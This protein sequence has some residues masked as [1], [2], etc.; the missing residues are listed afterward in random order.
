MTAYLEGGAAFI[1]DI[2]GGG[3]MLMQKEKEILRSLAGRYMDLAALPVQQE[4]IAMWKTL[5]AGSMTRPMVAVALDQIP[6][7]EFDSHE[8]L[9]LHV[10]DPFWQQIERQLRQ[11]LFQWAY[12]PVDMVI[13][14]FI[15][16][17]MAVSG[18]HYGIE[19]Q[20]ET[21]ATDARNDIVSHCYKNQLEEEADI[22]KIQDMRI[23]H[24]AAETARR[25][26]SANEIFGGI[27]PVHTSGIQFHAGLWD[28][29]T[30]FMGV[31]NIYFD[32]MD[33]PEFMHQIMRRFTDATVAGIKQANELDVHDGNAKLCHGSYIYTNEFLPGPAKG[34]GGKSQNSWAFGLAQLFSS[35][36]PDIT[37]EF[38]LPY[39]QEI[40]GYFG[41]LYYGCCERLDDRM[42]LILQIPNLRKVSCSPWNDRDVFAEKIGPEFIMSAKPNPAF[43]AEKSVDYGAVEKDLRHTAEAARRNHVNLELILNAVSTVRYDPARLTKWSE[44]AMHAVGGG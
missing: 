29:V 23:V 25:L 27:A 37:R 39:I 26:E 14:P 2:R 38:E 36:S 7:H 31:E 33:R 12:F 21:I 44:I 3:H 28:F 34:K 9:R 11:K 15:S 35:A 41:G 8:L 17:P 6:W 20:E 32:L 10:A 40:A 13:E 5:N 43:L 24:D 16:I 22:A 42:E 18:Q 19:I 1:A 30:Q 4:K